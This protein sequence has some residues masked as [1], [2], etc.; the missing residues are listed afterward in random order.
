MENN[1][2]ETKILSLEN[3]IIKLKRDAIEAEKRAYDYKQL[4][5]ISKTFAYKSC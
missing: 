5:G 3:E 4:Y 1:V 2:L